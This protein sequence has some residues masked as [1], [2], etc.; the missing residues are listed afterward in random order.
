[1]SVYIPL[2]ANTTAY[3][4]LILKIISYELRFKNI[5][6]LGYRSHSGLNLHPNI[7]G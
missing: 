6:M 2:P 5:K 3:K 4:S 7:R 1:M